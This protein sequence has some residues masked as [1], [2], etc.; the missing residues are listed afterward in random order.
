MF[1]TGKNIVFPLKRLNFK[2]GTQTTNAIKNVISHSR[3]TTTTTP[4]LPTSPDPAASSSAELT[5]R[6]SSDYTY[7]LFYLW[8]C[9]KENVDDRPDLQ[10]DA[11]FQF[12][13]PNFPHARQ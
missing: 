8:W 10:N 13:A 5:A 11:T 1:T 7:L 4:P 6:E 12:S 9:M 2:H 3:S